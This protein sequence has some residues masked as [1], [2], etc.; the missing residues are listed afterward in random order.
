MRDEAHTMA[1]QINIVYKMDQQSERAYTE[2]KRIISSGGFAPGQRLREAHLAELLGASRTPTRHALNRLESEGLVEYEARRGHK[3]KEFT[4][5][6]V[7]EIYAVRAL[8]EPEAVRLLATSGFD[9]LVQHKLTSLVHEMDL[10]LGSSQEYDR[11]I[12]SK[13]LALNHQFHDTLYTSSG[14]VYLYKLIV[15]VTDLP[16]ALRHFDNFHDEQLRQSQRDHHA[17]L[18][19]LVGREAE[20]AAALLREHILTARD[21]ML[22]GQRP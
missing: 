3:M 5:K 10:I 20:R 19:A 6:D 14:N 18:R 11:N 8:I 1:H 12:R 13:F 2:L 21:R 15:Q 7:E 16:L 4:L 22:V 9:S 17:I